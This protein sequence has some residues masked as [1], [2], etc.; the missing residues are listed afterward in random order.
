MEKCAALA[1]HFFC[2]S[3]LLIVPGELPDDLTDSTQR[4]QR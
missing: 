1:A 4:I 3:I 2:L